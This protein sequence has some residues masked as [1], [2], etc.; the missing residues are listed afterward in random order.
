MP[1]FADRLFRVLKTYC[2][3]NEIGAPACLLL[4]FVAHEQSLSVSGWWPAVFTDAELLPIIGIPR[5]QSLVSIRERTIA[6]GWLFY[7]PPAARGAG[8]SYSVTI[9]KRFLDGAENS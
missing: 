4:A 2:I 9:P 3:A 6:D 1:S 7:T 5:P 8:G